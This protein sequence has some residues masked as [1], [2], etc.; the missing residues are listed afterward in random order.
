MQ[1]DMFL[2]ETDAKRVVLIDG[3]GFVYR[4]FHALPPMSTPDGKPCNATLGFCRMVAAQ[5]R[6]HATARI[7]VVFE[8]NGGDHRRLISPDYKANRPEP[9]AA[10]VGQFAQVRD[11]AKAFGIPGIEVDGWE[12]DD[13][14]ATYA[15]MATRSGHTLTVVTSDKDMLQLVDDADV[16]IYHPQLRRTVTRTDVLDKFGVPPR[17]VPD[18]QALLGD[19]T[20]NIPGVEGIGKK[21]AAALVTQYGSL[22]A[23]L[24]SIDQVTPK[25]LKEALRRNE[26]NARLSM[27]LVTLRRDAPVPIALNRI[28]RN[29][30]DRRLTRWLQKMGF[31]ELLRS[32]NLRHL[33][34]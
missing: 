6:S 32:L 19:A 21:K 20:D 7:G 13:V 2:T 22:E 34:T 27:D 26:G 25:G 12:A 24:A 10:L 17:Q 14:I 33:T 23:I 28:A 5:M 18:V 11:A 15:G 31:D 8:R 1:T 16:E 9:P 30:D 29:H 3:Y 4:A